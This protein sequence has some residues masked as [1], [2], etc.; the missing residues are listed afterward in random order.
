MCRTSAVG[1]KVCGLVGRELDEHRL[2]EER[3]VRVRGDDA[4]ADPVR[5]IGS[6]PGVD[7]V[8]RVG[9]GEVGRDLLT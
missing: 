5:R 1:S 2:G 7:H 9:E 6:G 8:E 4:H 3:V